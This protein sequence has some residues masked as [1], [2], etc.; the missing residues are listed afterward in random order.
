MAKAKAKKTEAAAGA[1]AQAADQAKVSEGTK[2]PP[3]Q[4]GDAKIEVAVAE[5]KPVLLPTVEQAKAQLDVHP[6]RTSVLSKDGH[7]VRE[8]K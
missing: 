5:A 4:E 6:E 7:V 2:A 1:S 8:P 3:A